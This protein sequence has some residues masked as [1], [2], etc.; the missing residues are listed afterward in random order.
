MSKSRVQYNC[1]KC[2]HSFLPSLKEKQSAAG[3]SARIKGHGFERTK[4]KEIGKWWGGDYE[5]CR[6]PGSGGS[7]LKDGWDLAGDICTTATDFIYHMELKN[8]PS[9]FSGLQDLYLPKRPIWK[10]WEQAQKDCPSH[11]HPILIINRYNIP[12]YCMTVADPDFNVKPL[13]VKSDIAFM[14]FVSSELNKYYIWQYKDWL[15]S[16]PYIWGKTEDE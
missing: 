13:L 7:K 2:S 11:R 3:K 14:R 10:W 4:A 9:G 5:W 16:D 1:P 15:K 12:T 8:S 6:T